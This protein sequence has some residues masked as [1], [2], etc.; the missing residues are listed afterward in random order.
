MSGKKHLWGVKCPTRR[1]LLEIKQISQKTVFKKK[2]RSKV[3]IP[4]K[5]NAAKMFP[6]VTFTKNIFVEEVRCLAQIHIALVL[7]KN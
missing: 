4:V 1:G 6:K 7:S 5:K 2:I 3:I